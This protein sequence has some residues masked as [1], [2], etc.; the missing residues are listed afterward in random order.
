MGRWL[1]AGLALL[2]GATL[3]GAT[4]GCPGGRAFDRPDAD[5]FD[6][7]PAEAGPVAEG[8]V[9]NDAG[10]AGT[11]ADAADARF[12]GPFPPG[13]Y[14]S[15]VGSTIADYTFVGYARASAP[16]TSAYAMHDL[17]D[18]AGT[19]T[20][21]FVLVITG[22][23]CGG[24][25]TQLPFDAVR[26]I[27]GAGRTDVAVAA[28][29]LHGPDPAVLAKD[30]DARNLTSQINAPFFVGRDPQSVTARFTDPSVMPAVVYIDARSMKVV[31][32]LVG[33]PQD[34]GASVQQALAL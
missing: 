28:I 9:A 14:G 30:V 8:G 2:G 17:F 20:R 5:A 21:L 3:A 22:S 1:A 11:D 15:A 26:W 19:R 29:L 18:P 6:G 31:R 23:W 4:T 34:F 24:P 25:C 33:V 32:I 12:T 10:D 13:P 7:G 27:N 16:D